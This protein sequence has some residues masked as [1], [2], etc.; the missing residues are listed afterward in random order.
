MKLLPDEWMKDKKNKGEIYG[1][2]KKHGGCLRFDPDAED[3]LIENRLAELGEDRVLE[4]F[5]KGS[6]A[7]LM[8]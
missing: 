6:L 3:A 5:R 7:D 1:L 4:E 2:L 8:E